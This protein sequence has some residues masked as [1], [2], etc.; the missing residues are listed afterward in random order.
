MK[1]I[2]IRSSTNP[3]PRV[4]RMMEWMLGFHDDLE[5]WSPVR[6]N[7][8][9]IDETKFERTKLGQ[10]DYFGGRNVFAYLKFVLIENIRISILL[11]KRRKDI[12]LVHISDFE[13]SILP[14]VA[15]LLIR[16]PLI[17]NIHDNFSQRY[18][19]SAWISWILNMFEGLIVS[20]SSVTLVPE[21]FRKD[22]LPKFCKNKVYVIPNFSIKSLFDAGIEKHKNL[23]P[24]RFFYAGWIDVSRGVDKFAQLAIELKKKKVDVT[25]EIAGWGSNEIVQ[26]LTETLNAEGI[27]LCFYGQLPQDKVHKILL[28]THVSFA[29]YDT[30]KQINVLA[31]SNKIPEILASNTILVTNCGTRIATQL[32]QADAAILFKD[33][34]Q[35]AS[36]AIVELLNDF[37]KL[38]SFLTRQQEFVSTFYSEDA[39]IKTLEKVRKCI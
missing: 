1:A 2:F 6:S 16:V 17:Y 39:R 24:V 12:R 27:E 4:V 32:Q 5:Y 36:N 33:D 8:P 35:A 34:L 29:Y 28:D 10:Y 30:S 21:Q 9:I 19:N 37:E 26:S 3:G 20:S 31:A 25:V 13:L 18:G 7:D 38:N 14:S 11:F 15:L 23:S 22:S